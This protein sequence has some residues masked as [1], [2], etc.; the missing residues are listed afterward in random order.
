MKMHLV[1]TYDERLERNIWKYMEGVSKWRYFEITPQEIHTETKQHG[2]FEM[3]GTYGSVGRAF[4]DFQLITEGTACEFLDRDQIFLARNIIHAPEPPEALLFWEEPALEEDGYVFDEYVDRVK[5]RNYVLT[6]YMARQ[7]IV[8]AAFP[9]S[10][11][12]RTLE[13]EQ[14]QCFNELCR[15][16]NKVPKASFLP[17]SREAPLQIRLLDEDIPDHLVGATAV[18]RT[19]DHE[20]IR[21]VFSIAG[22]QADKVD[23]RTWKIWYGNPDEKDVVAERH[24]AVQGLFSKPRL[25]LKNQFLKALA[26]DMLSKKT[27]E[28]VYDFQAPV[29]GQYI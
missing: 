8:V 10:F 28:E 4:V 23:E 13:R 20:Y 15:E 7:G 16:F 27:Y 9:K 12:W 29:P 6:E 25:Q 2:Y 22:Q 11:D 1:E 3:T 19:R 18:Y 21:N 5:N 14:V 17:G 26:G 24:K